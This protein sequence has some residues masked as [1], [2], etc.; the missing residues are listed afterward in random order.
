M[1][2]LLSFATWKR[3]FKHMDTAHSAVTHWIMY[4]TSTV[5]TTVTDSAS[6]TTGRVSSG[7]DPATRPI[8]RLEAS[9]PIQ[10]LLRAISLAP[11][12]VIWL[13]LDT[14]QLDRT[15]HYQNR[16]GSEWLLWFVEGTNLSKFMNHES[17]D[18]ISSAQP[19]TPTSKTMQLI[20]FKPII[21]LAGCLCAY[22]VRH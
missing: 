6:A 8:I 21:P 22:L 4:S 7:F 12:P 9:I 11:V 20:E 10:T 1:P 15:D 2:T 14:S 19:H 17:R 18:M 13:L 3:E 5:M 16:H